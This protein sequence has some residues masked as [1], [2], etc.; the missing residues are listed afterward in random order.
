VTFDGSEAWPRPE[1]LRSLAAAAASTGHRGYCT[2]EELAP[3]LAG[4]KHPK[5]KASTQRTAKHPVEAREAKLSVAQL[6]AVLR[7]EMTTLTDR[8]TLLEG[9]VSSGPGL[10]GA[11]VRGVGMRAPISSEDALARLRVSQRG[12]GAAPQ[13]REPPSAAA[14]P[15]GRAAPPM[16]EEAEPSMTLTMAQ[17]IKVLHKQPSR[18]SAEEAFGLNTG[19][20]AGSEEEYEV[21]DV[22]GAPAEQAALAAFL[23]EEA[24]LEAA[25]KPSY[26]APR[27]GD[28]RQRRGRRGG[29]QGPQAQGQ[30]L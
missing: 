16:T 30:G 3:R 4:T 1:A 7:E 21:L 14:A 5:T 29:R 18:G 26:H 10:F 8:F 13:P 22:L 9:R 11:Q 20:A 17:V 15:P 6:R 19:A 25:R 2:A 28:T 23:R 12:A 24:A 27:K